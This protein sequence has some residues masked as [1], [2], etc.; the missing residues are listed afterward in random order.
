MK[1]NTLHPLRASL[2][3]LGLILAII[4]SAFP[5]SV[6]AAVLP[7]STCSEA[8]GVRTCD[9]YATTGT[10]S[11]PGGGSVTIWGYAANSGDPAS[12]P[13]PMLIA[14]SGETLV[15]VLHN[16]LGESTSLTIPG[17][18]G[19]SDLTG[20]GPGGTKSYI[21]PSLQPGTYIYQ[22][23]P[24]ANGERQVG[25]GMYG[26]LIVRPAGA[27]Q[28][29]YGPASTFD[30]EAVLV[31]SEVDTALNA[32]PTTFDMR[33]YTP[34]YFLFN[35]KGY[36]N[37]DEMDTIAGHKVLLR[38]VNAGIQSHPIGV[39]G[40][41]YTVLSMDGKPFAYPYSA[42]SETL[43]AGQTADLLVTIPATAP[44]NQRYAVYN[45]SMR[46]LNN[47]QRFGGMLTFLHVLGSTGIGDQTGPSASGLSL[48]P[49][50]SNGSSLITLNATLTDAE[51]NV[52]QAEYFLDAAGADGSGILMNASDAA[53][54]DLTEAVT[55]VIDPAP[56]SSGSHVVYVHGKDAAGNWGAFKSVVLILDKAGPS[57]SSL[58]AN[59][60][61]SSGLVSVSISGTASDSASGNSNVVDAEFFIDVLGADGSGTPMT[62]NQTAPVVSLSGT[63]PASTMSGLSEGYHWVYIHAQ[64]SYG[65]WGPFGSLQFG[66]D[67][68]GPDAGNVQLRPNPNNGSLPYSPSI[69][70]VRVDA[71][72]TEPGSGAVTSA[73][74][75]AEFFID[76]VG[77]NGTG[78]LMTPTD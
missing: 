39:L 58:S 5:H 11:L 76:T 16:N 3:T 69:Q 41:R 34:R 53:F 64:D 45:P 9:L 30:D 14:N 13:G 2:L 4:A 78:I 20:A 18:G 44:G 68:T 62:R 28:E 52:V 36:P 33:N 46:L 40:L 55:A 67:K 21:F 29:A 31:M 71:R 54:D 25:M 50:P 77:A 26:V 70:S 6:S 65:N 12:L 47:N 19:V 24:T 73:V 66:V 23:G 7:A 43:G 42:V 32:A 1:T 17:L 56:M 48:T 51:N 38:V 49:N 27:P 61:P 57:I 63:I 74:K 60:N 59:P 22:A 37:T 75:N 35:G 15:V 8:G 10:L 72:F